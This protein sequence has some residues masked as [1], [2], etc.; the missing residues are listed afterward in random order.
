[1]KHI[2]Y[3]IDIE[4]GQYIILDAELPLEK[5]KFKEGD[6][7]QVCKTPDGC[8]MFKIVDPIVKFALGFPRLDDEG[9]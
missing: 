2:D 1:M 3:T 5:I 6:I 7:L 9:K 4:Y 8:A